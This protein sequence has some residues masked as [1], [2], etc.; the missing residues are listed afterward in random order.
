MFSGDFEEIL[1]KAAKDDEWLNDTWM[2]FISHPDY[3][4]LLEFFD[5]D[6]FYDCW[7]EEDRDRKTIDK[8]LKKVVAGK[9]RLSLIQSA[10]FLGQLVGY[11]SHYLKYRND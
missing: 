9:D 4:T 10:F 7:E 2:N 3:A 5:K 1:D 8:N 6:N 11:A